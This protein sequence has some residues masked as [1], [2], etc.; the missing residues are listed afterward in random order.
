MMHCHVGIFY[1]KQCFS[2]L[3]F[4]VMILIYLQIEERMQ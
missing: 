1:W 2:F 4:W 3:W